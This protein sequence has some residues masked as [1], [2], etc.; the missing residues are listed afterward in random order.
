MQEKWNKK[1]ASRVP[2]EQDI[3]AYVKNPLWDR[4]CTYLE[5]EY[6]ARRIVEYSRCAVPGW[7][8]KYKKSGRS[9]CTLYPME[10]YFIALIVIGEREKNE[11]ELLLPSLGSYLQALY[12]DTKT[13]MGQKWLMIE[14]REEEV[15]NDV[16]RCVA[17]RAQKKK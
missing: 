3:S 14:V 9:L 8:V 13:G 15:L 2:S 10:G 4:L 16:K 11:M 5:E 6:G 12:R 7:N 17:I 1:D